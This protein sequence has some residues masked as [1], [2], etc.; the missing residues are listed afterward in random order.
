MRFALSAVDHE[1]DGLTRRLPI[2]ADA[3]T[4]TWLSPGG[5]V[6]APPDCPGPGV[7]SSSTP[8]DSKREQS[9]PDTRWRDVYLYERQGTLEVGPGRCRE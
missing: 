6:V 2:V 4:S 9:K 8:T 1:C 7:T 3:A 5:F